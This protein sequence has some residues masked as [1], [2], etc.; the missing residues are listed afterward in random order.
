MN[1]PESGRRVRVVT[2]WEPLSFEQIVA[3]LQAWADKQ[4]SATVGDHSG[5]SRVAMLSGVLRACP[6][7]ESL[8]EH[9]APD[10]WELGIDTEGADRADATFEFDGTYCKG[11]Q[12]YK[13][14]RQFSV[15]I[16]QHMYVEIELAP[17]ESPLSAV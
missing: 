8:H 7:E 2:G 13:D 17:G 3:L 12:L 10:H 9:V 15:D 5:P 4:V 1:T 11:G 6:H 16:G 14:R